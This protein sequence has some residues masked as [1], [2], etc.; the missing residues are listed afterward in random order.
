MA[1]GLKKVYLVVEDNKIFGANDYQMVR[2]YRE[3]S[4]AETVC[5]TQNQK[6]KDDATLLSNR[7][8]PTPVYKVHAFWLLHEDMVK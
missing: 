7:D 8:K 3:K 4:S 6:A 5:A 1:K 2:M